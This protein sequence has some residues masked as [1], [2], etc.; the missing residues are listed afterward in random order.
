MQWKT[1]VVERLKTKPKTGDG[2]NIE[3]LLALMAI[4][5]LIT[6]YVTRRKKCKVKEK[7][8]YPKSSWLFTKIDDNIL[9]TIE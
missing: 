9:I 2:A 1:H 3:I 7:V 5:T 4:S 8:N 6:V